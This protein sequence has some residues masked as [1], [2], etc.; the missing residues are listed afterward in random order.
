MKPSTMM[1]RVIALA[2][3]LTLAEAAPSTTR[4]L[5]AAAAASPSTPP[6][7]LQINYAEGVYMIESGSCG[8]TGLTGSL[9]TSTSSCNAAATALDLPDKTAS[10]VSSSDNMFVTYPM[11]CLLY[12]NPFAQDP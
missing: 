10:A 1:V 11:G 4:N 5:A 9:I 8:T 3:A 7:V 2:S 12:E 6:G